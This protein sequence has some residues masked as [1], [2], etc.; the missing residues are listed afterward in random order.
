M[1]LLRLLVS[2]RCWAM[3]P[4]P[5][6]PACPLEVVST[7][8]RCWGHTSSPC[9]W[10]RKEGAL[11]GPGL[12]PWRGSLRLGL[13]SQAWAETTQTLKEGCSE[14]PLAFPIL[15][16]PQSFFSSH[17]YPCP[18]SHS[19]PPE[20]WW[21]DQPQPQ[22]ALTLA[23][24]VEAVVYLWGQAWGWGPLFLPPS[25][26]PH[27]CG[28]ESLGYTESPVLEGGWGTKGEGIRPAFRRHRGS[29]PRLCVLQPGRARG[30]GRYREGG[31]DP[32]GAQANPPREGGT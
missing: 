22:P 17:S 12:G 7:A 30:G 4:P 10:L 11:A 29:T 2:C 5:R 20:N 23:E 31:L 15:P 32:L 1:E 14:G 13:P 8:P 27:K 25:P 21:R 28:P 18:H 16:H 24:G 9:T 6:S 19:V 26:P 3:P